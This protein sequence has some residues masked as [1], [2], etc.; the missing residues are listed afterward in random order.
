[1]NVRDSKPVFLGRFNYLSYKADKY[2]IMFVP[3][4]GA[5]AAVIARNLSKEDALALIGELNAAM[6]DVREGVSEVDEEM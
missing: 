2:N 6:D 3:F 5:T 4:V 1:M